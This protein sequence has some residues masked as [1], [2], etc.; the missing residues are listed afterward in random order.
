MGL[1]DELIQLLVTADIEFAESLEEIGQVLD[2]RIT[3]RF[4]LVILLAREPF[5][6]M[7]NQLGQFGGKRF[8]GEAYGF[9]EAACTRWHSCW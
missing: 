9:V 6:Q 2:R 1:A 4:R 8:L 3:K 7:R 5:R